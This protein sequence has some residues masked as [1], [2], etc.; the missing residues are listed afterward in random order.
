MDDNDTPSMLKKFTDTY[1]HP[2]SQKW[3][4]G[5][6]SQCLNEMHKEPEYSGRCRSD[7]G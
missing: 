1:N 6:Y 4:G 7:G 2:V 3:R 5:I